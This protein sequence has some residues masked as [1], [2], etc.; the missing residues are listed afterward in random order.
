[1]TDQ[2]SKDDAILDEIMSE[3][4]SLT[5]ELQ[6]D[7]LAYINK[8]K[9]PRAYPR[10]NKPI[11]MDVLVGGKVIQSNAKNVSAS[12]VLINSRMHPDIGIPA[13]IVFSVPGQARPF[14]LT[15]TVVR[16]D[17]GGIALYFSEMTPYAREHLGSLLKGI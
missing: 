8:L 7:V 13:K 12:G 14:K 2:F 1:M 4:R 3:V 11:E 6:K 9:D 16:T 10:V 15:G 17:S 5:E